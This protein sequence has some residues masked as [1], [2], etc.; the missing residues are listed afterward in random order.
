MV[1]GWHLVAW[2]CV[3]GFVCIPGLYYHR[4]QIVSSRSGSRQTEEADG[5]GTRSQ[6]GSKRREEA[7]ELEMAA[8]AACRER[9][10]VGQGMESVG[11]EWAGPAHHVAQRL[12]GPDQA[13]AGQSWSR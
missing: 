2:G 4:E 5:L 3:R 12:R 9:Q 10:E 7:D 13:R 8:A 1:M 11:W 6:P